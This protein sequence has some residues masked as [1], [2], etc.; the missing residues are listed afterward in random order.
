MYSIVIADDELIEQKVLEKMT[1]QAFPSL[2]VLPSVKNGSELMECVTREN[3]DIAV[4]DINMPVVSGLD[5]LEW[6]R[7]K[8]LATKVLIVSAYSEFQYAQKAMNLNAAGYILKPV[9]RDE[10]IRALEKLVSQLDGEREEKS[11][12]MD[13]EEWKRGYRRTL[14]REM[15]SDMLL[16]EARSGTIERYR[17]QCGEALEGGAVLCLRWL[18]DGESHEAEQ[19]KI[20]EDLAR[21]CTCFGKEYRDTYIL[22]LFL[23]AEEGAEQF[24]DWILR[25]MDELRRQNF[26]LNWDGIAI[27]VSSWKAR[28]QEFPDAIRE[29]TAAVRGAAEGGCYLYDRKETDFRSDGYQR[30]L[31]ECRKLYMQGKSRMLRERLSALSR[32]QNDR[33]FT[34]LFLLTL[35]CSVCEGT[36]PS[37]LFRAAEDTWRYWNELC[38]CEDEEQMLA[39]ADP[40]TA[41]RTEAGSTSPDI[42]LYVDACRRYLLQ[43]YRE[44]VSLE[45]TAEHIG[46]SGFYL[47]RIMKQETGETFLEHL[48]GIRLRV[49]MDLLWSSSY[50]F[51][52]IAEECGYDSASYLS[53]L[54][55]KKTGLN[56]GDLRRR[57]KQLL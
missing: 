53:K 18:S 22:F 29:S 46:I 42:Q 43:H 36:G 4:L 5:A 11:R 27:G 48:T 23:P 31:Q 9:D 44:E 13:G 57:L 2:R 39:L 30:D 32:K 40:Q 25:I 16:G 7:L 38:A 21:L 26:R 34:R 12:K 50:T 10:Y 47:S 45:K 56:A 33:Q 19:K 14:E 41:V 17:E 37:R 51:Q 24:R 49:A 55:K 54:L 6:L 35:R 52:M 28:L 1:R 20:L 3:P 15:I 8:G